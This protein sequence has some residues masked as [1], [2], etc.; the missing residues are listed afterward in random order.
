MKRLRPFLPHLLA[1]LCLGLSA[2]LQVA[3]LHQLA[4][5]QLRSLRQELETAVGQLAARSVLASQLTQPEL[6]APYRGLLLSPGW[7]R[8]RAAFDNLRLPQLHKSARYELTADSVSIMLRLHLVARPSGRNQPAPPIYNSNLTSQT[9]Q[10]LARVETRSWRYLTR[11]TDSLLAMLPGGPPHGSHLRHSYGREAAP[12]IGPPVGAWGYVSQPYAY[13]NL[14]LRLYQLRVPSLLGAV[15]YRLRFQLA[16]AGLLLGL[17]AATL[18]ALL[19]LLRQQRRYAEARLDFARN[20][21]HELK[22]PVATVALALEAIG[23]HQAA[24]QPAWLRDYLAIGQ[25]ELQ[26]LGYLL[27][28]ALLASH[29]P[30]R[31]LPP[32]RLELYDVQQGVVQAVASLRPRLAQQQAHLEVAPSPEPCFVLGDPVHLPN[33]LYNLLE[34]ALKHGGVGVGLAVSCTCE[35]HVVCIQVRDDGP[36]IAPAYQRRVFEPLF[37]APGPAAFPVAEGSGLGLHYVRQ[38]VEQHGGRITLT[39]RPGAG[40]C[41]T[42]R[43]PRHA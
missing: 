1:C 23:R 8:L 40:S 21:T 14:H 7:G 4:Q 41:F 17:T 31:P 18:V 3:W 28:A 25:Q 36:G 22:T 5:G 6:V 9:P 26:R 35:R 19:R 11:A 29:A 15:A 2:A 43:L 30:T 20:M 32:L 27:D 37:R 42:I 24:E 34:N 10:R 33:V 38:L 12:P 13:N 39:S 16:A